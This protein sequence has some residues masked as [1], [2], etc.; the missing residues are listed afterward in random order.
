M[1]PELVE[2]CRLADAEHAICIWK[3]GPSFQRTTDQRRGEPPANTRCLREIEITAAR[4]L[5]LWDAL[6]FTLEGVVKGSPGED[7]GVEQPAQNQQTA[8]LELPGEPA[9]VPLKIQPGRQ[10]GAECVHGHE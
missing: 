3:E 4:R 8:D 6:E 1:A 5:S 10:S 7:R 9:H 2:R